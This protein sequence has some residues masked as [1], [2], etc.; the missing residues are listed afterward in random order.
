VTQADVATPRQPFRVVAPPSISARINAA[1]GPQGRRRPRWIAGYLTTAVLVDAA[2]GLLAGVAAYEIRFGRTPVPYAD[3]YLAGTVLLPLAF[4]L[5]LAANRAYDDRQ[6]FVGSAEYERVIRAG[7]ALTA[8]AAIVSYALNVALS[9]GYVLIAL[10]LCVLGCLLGRFL[11]RRRLHRARAQGRCMQRVL[12]VGHPGAISETTRQLRRERFHGLDVVGACVPRVVSDTIASVDVPVR[13]SF[14]DVHEAVVATG[15]DTVLVLSCPELNG[16]SLRR[17]AWQVEG[18]DV[19]LV[20]ASSLIDVAGARTTI[21]PVDGLPLM[22]IE[23]PTLTGIRPLLKSFVDRVTALIMLGLLAPV[24]AVIAVTIASTSAGPVYFRQVRIGRNGRPFTMLKFRS[25]SRDAWKM[26]ADLA[27]HNEASGVL[28][29]L[30]RDPRVT[31]V[32][33][34]LRRYSLDELPQLINVL[35]G[36]MSLVGPRPALPAEVAAYPDDVYRRLVVRPGLTG[37]WQVSGRSD[38]AWEEAVRLDLR[39][40]ENWSLGLDAVIIIRTL[41]AVLRGQGAY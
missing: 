12:I 1:R 6:L 40:V 37:L 34:L 8:G 36:S 32:G 4:V 14:T 13:G 31:P 3:A 33:R 15:A 41:K 2:A 24:F 22:H 10:P 38:L 39:Y 20:V 5:V 28:F 18:D 11:L 30:K 23:H 21:R 27:A 7:V 35:R 19:D 9:R 26:Q 25:M 16:Q 29:K 17:L